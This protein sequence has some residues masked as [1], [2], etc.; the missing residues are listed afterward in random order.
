MKKPLGY[1]LALLL[2]TGAALAQ[3]TPTGIQKIGAV[4]M[5]RTA[6]KVSAGPLGTVESTMDT[7]GAGFQTLDYTNYTPPQLPPI[8]TIGPCLVA[9]L[10]QNT[11]ATG[12]VAT[13]LDAGPVM[14]VNGPN[15][16]KQFA[17]TKTA[18]S[19]SYGGVLG[20][21][22]ALPI[23]GAPPVAPLYLDPG[24]YTVDNGSGGADIGP[25][26]ATLTLPNPPFVWTNADADL[27]IDRSAGVDV[28]W[29]GGDPGSKVIIQGASATADPVTRQATGGAFTCI[30]DNTGDFVVTSDV[31]A[32]VPA[33]PTGAGAAGISTL[34]VSSGVT[35]SFDAPG[36][37]LSNILFQ[38][39]AG[40]SV[41][42]K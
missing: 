23:P 39:G 33:T 9:N 5:L 8:T 37:D 7:F 13:P 3:D 18:R 40:R 4:S 20:G 25:F 12:V 6:S 10:A 14:N 26:T 41:V 36:S 34:S 19:I 28:Q 21:G 30:V 38:S 22:I 17:V 16:S 32:I 27:S 2:T 24:T 11:V 42:Y 31:L 15:G 1:F 29:T 35:A